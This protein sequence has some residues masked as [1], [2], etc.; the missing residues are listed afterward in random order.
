MGLRLKSIA[1]SLPNTAD[2]SSEAA[3]HVERPV[4]ACERRWLSQ[5]DLLQ[6]PALF[7]PAQMQLLPFSGHGG[8]H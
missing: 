8:L 5:L 3:E 6:G 2:F 7:A 4:P 1:K